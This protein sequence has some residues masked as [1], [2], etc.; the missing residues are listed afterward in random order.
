MKIAFIHYHLKTG[1]VTTVLR[2]QV[3][4]IMDTCDVL[5]L[6]GT[7]PG[8]PFPCDIAVIPDLGYDTPDSKR[9][10]PEDVAA[11]IIEAIGKKWKSGCDLIHVHNPTLKKNKHFITILNILKN[12]KNRLFLQ[13]HDFAE[14]GRPMSYYSDDEY[15]SDSHY[16]VINSRDYHVLLK[17]GLKK[18]GLHNIPN[19]INPFTY[20]STEAPSK[21]HVL[22]PIRAIRRKN[23]GEAILLSLF[24]KHHETLAITLPPNSPADIESYDGWKTFANDKS[25][26][27]LFDAGLK[28]DYPELLRSSKFLITT[29][30]TEGFGFSFLEPWTARKMLLGRK[31]PG[32][33]DDF[34]QKGVKL[35][36]LYTHLAVPIEWLGKENVFDKWQ[37]CVKRAA[38]LFNIAIDRDTIA[39]AFEKT[40][41]N[42][43]I[44]FGF[45]DEAFQK[46]IISRVLSHQKDRD[47]LAHLNPNLLTLGDVSNPDALIQNNMKAV[48]KYYN[49]SIYKDTLVDI[50]KKVIAYSVDHSIDK[51]MLLSQFF[52]P[53]AM[54][55]L[56]WSEY[57][58]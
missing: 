11:S 5:V 37:I 23:V 42:N 10:R 27:I 18:E 53:E 38:Q 15:V 4:A 24:F 43:C 29:S 2:Q 3:E 20:R 14:D 31:L 9:I 25:L 6:S 33:C 41:Q 45:L 49:P 46:T 16:G 55:M 19:T 7:S 8:S 17:S 13:V 36:H 35:D 39:R 44:D 22:Y 47:R 34:E 40:T 51:H 48:L 1:G 54:R 26:N 12:R 52:K 58:E 32:I 30:I 28:H 56:N 57:I 50:Y 21:N